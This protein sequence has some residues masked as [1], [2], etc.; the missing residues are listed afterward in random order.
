MNKLTL[1][2][3]SILI[4]S[5][6]SKPEV[7]KQDDPQKHEL[8]ETRIATLEKQLFADSIGTLDKT[9]AGIALSTYAEF[10]SQFPEDK[11]SGEYLFKAAQLA[12]ALQKYDQAIEY[13][14]IIETKYSSYEKAPVATFL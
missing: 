5:C 3:L 12:V 11:K 7:E 4:I 9:Q 6:N 13:Y 8:F 1:V 14:N 10:V 2:L